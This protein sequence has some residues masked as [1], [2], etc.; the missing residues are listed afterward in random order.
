MCERLKDNF[1]YLEDDNFWC[2]FRVLVFQSV[3]YLFREEQKRIGENLCL[4]NMIDDQFQSFRFLYIFFNLVYVEVV[5]FGIFY[6]MIWNL[7]N[8]FFCDRVE[9]SGG[10]SN[11]NLFYLEVIFILG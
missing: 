5:F 9:V 3:Y 6:E 7:D 4:V 11:F 8:F 1:W 2:Y 10:R